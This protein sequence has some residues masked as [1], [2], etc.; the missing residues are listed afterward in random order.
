MRWHSVYFILLR[1]WELRASI[2][3]FQGRLRNSEDT[4]N[5][6]DD[7]IYYTLTDGLTAGDWDEVQR[8]IDFLELP[9]ELTKRLEGLNSQSGAGS[10]WQTLTC[11]QTLWVAY[12]DWSAQLAREED[13]YLK[14]GVNCSY[15]KL[16]S[17]FVKLIIEPDVSYYCIATVLHLA[18]RLQWFKSHWRKFLTWHKK[19]EKSIQDVFDDYVRAEESNNIVDNE[20]DDSQLTQGLR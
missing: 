11:L 4:F 7:C 19:A 13:G 14:S 6:N 3:E 16:Q 9:T 5:D 15:E 18:L 1:C 20:D 2:K 12:T 8:F 17:Y 10:L